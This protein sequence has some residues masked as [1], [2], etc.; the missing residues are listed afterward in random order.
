MPFMQPPREV[1]AKLHIGHLVD[2]VV[3]AKGQSKPC[4]ERLTLAVIKRCGSKFIG[5]VYHRDVGRSLYHGLR[6]LDLVHFDLKHIVDVRFFN[7][8]EQAEAKKE[9]KI[10]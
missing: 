2:I 8:A 10:I 1:L 7:P 6:P 4:A 3:V 9:V 5:Q